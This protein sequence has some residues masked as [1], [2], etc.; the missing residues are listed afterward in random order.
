MSLPIPGEIDALAAL[1]PAPLRGFINHHPD[2]PK[3]TA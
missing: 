3:D 2:A 1:H